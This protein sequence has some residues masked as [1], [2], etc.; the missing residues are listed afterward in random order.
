MSPE[1][2]HP[3]RNGQR[4]PVCLVLG[5]IIREERLRRGWN[6]SQL[7]DLSGVRRQ[8]IDDIEKGETRPRVETNQRLARAFGIA[9]SELEARAERRVARW[10]EFCAKCSYFCIAG[11]RLPRLNSQRVCTRPK[12]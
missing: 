4:E 9:G 10:P 2:F 7:A 3:L 1:H 12:C 8:S 11:G 6:Q 5:A